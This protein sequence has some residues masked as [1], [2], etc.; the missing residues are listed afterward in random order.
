MVKNTYYCS[1]QTMAQYRMIE[2]LDYEIHHDLAIEYIDNGIVYPLE[3]NRHPDYEQFG[4]VT[5]KDGN[6]VRLSLLERNIF[7]HD[8]ALKP[9]RDWY[10]GANPEYTR[11]DIRKSDETVVFFGVLYPH[12]CHAIL[13]MLSRIWYFLDHPYCKAVYI[14]DSET[15][16]EKCFLDFVRAFG[17]PLEKLERITRPT[18]FRQ[19][20]VPEQSFRLHDKF[21]KKHAEVLARIRQN[22]PLEK[23]DLY[24]I[25][26]KQHPRQTVWLWLKNK[27]G[28]IRPGDYKRIYLLKDPAFT[29]QG[30]PRFSDM[31]IGRI[32]KKNGYKLV[33]PERISVTEVVK[34]LG[35]CEDLAA[36]SGTNAHQV[37]WMNDRSK[38]IVLNRSRH[39]CQIQNTLSQ[40][41]DMD[42]T[43]VDASFNLLPVGWM[44]GP[45]LM[46]VTTYL[47][48]FFKERHFKYVPRNE[49][50]FIKEHLYD[51]LLLYA[52]TNIYG[53]G[54][55][56]LV[57]DAKET[58]K[59]MLQAF[60]ETDVGNKE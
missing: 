41:K 7:D 40:M 32:F 51:F 34:V 58:A 50:K 57:W 52:K 47:E 12:Y 24:R 5:D 23:N 9:Y 8:D 37:W 2:N 36:Q 29:S 3:R 10:I 55:K 22:L 54:R 56:R 20:I 33:N 39:A 31:H 28:L 44:N 46:C 35:L 6:F 30:T 13:E 49:K 27:L 16:E 14:A 45:F 48:R 25:E 21:H 18:Q 60:Q 4:G 19:V 1:E 17:F 42:T 53:N 11:E 26:K 59:E 38:V 43:Y 15:K